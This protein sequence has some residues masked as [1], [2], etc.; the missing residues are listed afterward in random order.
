[1]TIAT[2]IQVCRLWTRG[3]A[4]EPFYVSP[5]LDPDVRMLLEPY[6]RLTV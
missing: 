4:F 2:A 1:V 6:R 5:E 3:P